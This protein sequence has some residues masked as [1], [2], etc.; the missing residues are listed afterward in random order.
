MTASTP[1]NLAV[2]KIGSG[3]LT[4]T[5]AQTANTATGA[6]TIN[7]G[8][9]ILGGASGGA[10]FAT[11]NVDS[12]ATFTLDNSVAAVTDRLADAALVNLQG[13]TL[14]YVANASGAST[15]TIGTLAPL[16]AGGSTIVLDA[17]GTGSLTLTATNLNAMDDGST[18]L[19][20]GSKLG[21]ASAAG[22]TNL[23]ATNWNPANGQGAGGEGTN[24]V[25]I[26]P[27][28]VAIDTS[29]SNPVAFVTRGASNYLRPLAASE[30]ASL[31]VGAGMGSNA[32]PTTA[33]N[34][35]IL[36]PGTGASL[37]AFP[38]NNSLSYINSLTLAGGATLSAP[39]F[40][41]YPTT[42]ANYAYETLYI[43]SGGILVQ[44]GAAATID[45]GNGGII[46]P[47]FS[48]ARN[49][50]NVHAYADLTL[51]AYFHSSSP[52]LT[53]SGSGAMTI[54]YQQFYAGPTSIN[55]G[56]VTLASTMPVN[57]TMNNPLY[58]APVMGSFTLYDLWVN[59]G[60]LDLKDKNQMVLN[61]RSTNPMANMGGVVTNSGTGM[62][63]LTVG[64]NATGTFGGTVTGNLSFIKAGGSTLTL[65]SFSS[66]S[67]A[68]VVS[69]GTLELKDSGAIQNSMSLDVNFGTLQ[70][71]NLGVANVNDRL[72]TNV[73]VTLRGGVINLYGAQGLTSTQSLASVTASQG[74]STLYVA[75]GQ[76]GVA[77]V[78]VGN[79]TRTNLGAGMNFAGTNLG[80]LYMDGSGYGQNR[81]V[82]HILLTQING[83]DPMA[84]V[85]ANN[86]IIGG[87][88]TVADR[89]ASY[90]PETGLS[91]LNYTGQSNSAPA[92]LY[93]AGPTDNLD[94]SMGGTSV[95]TR[96][97]NSIRLTGDNTFIRMASASD[98]LTVGSGGMIWWMNGTNSMMGGQ[99]SAGYT[100]GVPAELFLHIFSNATIGSQI[101]DNG[102]GG[103]V[104]LVKNFAQAA[105]TGT[106]YLVGANTYGGGTFI[107]SG[108]ANLATTTPGTITVPYDQMN[109][110]ANGLVIGAATV[111]M[112]NFPGQ[113]DPRN[114]VTIN[115]NGVL[116]LI[117]ANTLANLTFNTS[118]GAGNPAVN[119][120]RYLTLTGNSI[121]VRNDNANQYAYIG[122]TQLDL[123]NNNSFNITVNGIAPVGLRIEA[124]I[125]NGG[126]V[127]TGTGTLALSGRNIF[128]GGLTVSEG[129][130]LVN[131]IDALGT[132][133]LSMGDN[134]TFMTTGD[135][136]FVNPVTLNGAVNLGGSN[137]RLLGPITLAQNSALNTVSP[138][139]SAYVGPMTGPGGLTKNGPGTLYMTGLG[140]TLYNG[141]TVVNAGMLVVNGISGTSPNSDVTI[142]AGAMLSF[143]VTPGGRPLT[144]RSRRWA[145]SPAP[146]P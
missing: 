31:V 34:A 13:G 127:K 41:F 135:L 65:S 27:D 73:P 100:A 68:T 144:R 72:P 71:N 130:L 63:V 62:S 79:L 137:V 9:L 120:D 122:G 82:S 101:V 40:W 97:V 143:D 102:E 90:N 91:G 123:N 128:N 12:G 77:D 93:T 66:Y 94:I 48:N 43:N 26:R 17:N 30:M 69:G 109:S 54:N 24:Y 108:T 121:A 83:A 49:P 3:K 142:N 87:W 4:L 38:S 111:N 110:G 134:T 28:M 86:G 119:F 106:L 60:T 1:A 44:P 95:T 78:T 42:A 23:V 105:N 52:S 21:S 136:T 29:T 141:P 81:A 7:G 76:F 125:R 146:A 67:G 139:L 113:I 2:T 14:R 133:P 126:I 80:G 116:N 89:F 36:V 117:G 45:M 99:L 50:I 85:N 46:D 70:V 58:M 61:L 96:T 107:N 88:A 5:A 84:T 6:A 59:D 18:I 20:V 32:A 104:T 39:A 129:G 51:S 56:Y 112:Q 114:S 22:V 47:W 55:G 19:L 64:Q 124:A 74:D 25:S 57:S 115:G 11:V 75:A 16:N 33:K 103:Y 8:E 35:N 98:R 15:E 138:F 118:G 10:K 132:G 37:V 145:A 140:G 92:T 131:V 53:K